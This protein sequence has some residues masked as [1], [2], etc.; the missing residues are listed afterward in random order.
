[1]HANMHCRAVDDRDVGGNAAIV[2]PPIQQRTSA[3]ASKQ[4]ELLNEISRL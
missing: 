1:M 2:D 4:Q 3:E